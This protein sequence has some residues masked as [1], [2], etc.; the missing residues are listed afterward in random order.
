M[1]EI[2]VLICVRKNISLETVQSNEWQLVKNDLPVVLKNR[3]SFFY[4]SDIQLCWGHL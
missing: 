4:Q 1:T 2:R 3:P